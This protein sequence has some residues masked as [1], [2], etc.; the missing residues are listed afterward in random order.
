MSTGVVGDSSTSPRIPIVEI[1]G[2]AAGLA[3][4][5]PGQDG[6]A[7]KAIPDIAMA[8]HHPRLGLVHRMIL[9]GS[10][11]VVSLDVF[12]T[13]LWRRV[14]RPADVFG[15]LGARL[16]A[17]GRL[18]YWVTDATFRR[19][20]IDAERKSRSSRNGLGSEVSLFDIWQAMPRN[21]FTGSRLEELVAAE[22]ELEREFTVVDL[23]I[24]E[25]IQLAR[26]HGMPVI[27]VSDTYFTQPQLAYLLDRPELGALA[28]V[29]I[30]R[31]QQY[32]Q[33]K[34]SGLFESVLNE[35]G[36]CP[37]QVVHIGDNERADVTTPGELGIRTVHY[38]RLD[39]PFEAMLE[40]EGEPIEPFGEYAPFLDERHGDFGLTSMRAKTLQSHALSSARPMD[41]AWRF[42]AA[43]LGPV[44][45]GFAQWAVDWARANGVRTLWCA[46]REG[47]LLSELINNAARV[48]GDPVVAKPI[49]LSR[50]V[51]SI[52]SLD[53]FDT[54][55]MHEFIRRSYQLSVRQTLGLLGL[56]PGDVPALAGV[57][58]TVI[59]NGS[60]AEK[61]STALTETPHLRNRIKVMV[62]AARQRLIRS[63]KSAGALDQPDLTLVD[64]GW[65]ATI[66]YQLANA[67]RLATVDVTPRGLYLATDRRSARVQLAG[68]RAEGYLGQAGHPAEV[69]RPMVRSPEFIEQ[70][71]NAL[72]GSLI[73]F[74]D[75][76]EPVLGPMFEDESQLAERR[77][78]QAGIRAFQ[79]NWHRYSGVQDHRPDLARATAARDRLANILVSAIGN[80][81]ADEVAVFGNWVHDDNFGSAVITR[82]LPDDLR[83][84]IPYLSPNDL[85]DL[86]MRDAFW[87]SLVAASDPQL[88]AA[89]SAVAAGVVDPVVFEPSGEPFAC[90]LK[91]RTAD[92]HE[93]AAEPHRVRINRN[94]LS[95]ARMSFEHHDTVD[96]ALALPGRP[97]VVRIDWIEARIIAGG[98][99]RQQALRWD[100]TE[101]LANLIF[102]DGARW[103]GGN[104]IE[105]EREDAT[106]WL[107]LAEHAGAPV[108]SGQVSVAF[109]MLPQSRSALSP[110]LALAGRLERISVRVLQEYRSR[111]VRGVAAGAAR[112]AT[113]K[114]GG[115]R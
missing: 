68:L 90:E 71:V 109:A 88:A 16:R 107:R 9:D 61:V 101:D 60:I 89:A 46:M 82:L 47:E 51:T 31:S 67:L 13:V 65:G 6:S 50:H 2:S 32:G 97:A 18:P 111:G 84:A 5:R 38:R 20:R 94:G 99:R 106:V 19:M 58:D 54:D 72:C 114:L 21:L 93:Y 27:L 52:A 87:P 4:G 24:A 59:D 36:C 15:I 76:G 41:T 10:C 108:S 98:H 91:Y 105:F 79:R 12:D 45:T 62:T 40:R 95:F 102:G 85:A 25:I 53:S 57:L 81:T 73:G 83:A 70:C 113:R 3:E 104:M 103:L 26:Q 35:I 55:S 96:V 17:D 112:V 92:G 75:A 30:F 11:S 37:E 63:L 49:W 44:L 66:Q 39:A 43:V 22:V 69:V 34:S 80:P 23:D 78:V 110:R 33:D 77:A 14:P 115:L 42:G 8:R 56:R 28:N 48:G 29:R 100:T 1:I 7:G 74:T 86:T 64:L